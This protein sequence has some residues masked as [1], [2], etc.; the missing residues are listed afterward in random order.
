[1]A[2]TL[3]IKTIRTG[4]EP[5]ATALAE[6]E[7]G[8]KQVAAATTAAASGKLY[9]GEDV[10]GNAT[11]VA[12]AFGIGIKSG[13]GTTQTGVP[14]GGNLEIAAGS[15]ISTTGSVSGDVATVT[16]AATGGGGG[17]EDGDTIKFADGDASTPGLVLNSDAD[18]GFY[19]TGTVNELGFSA[20]GTGQVIFDDG[21]IKPVTDNDVDLGT[22]T[23]AFKN[24]YV[25]GNIFLTN[26]GELDIASGGDFTIDSSN[27]IKFDSSA[28]VWTYRDDATEIFR[29][30][31]SSSDVVMKNAV[32]AKDIIFTQYDDTETF[33]LTDD[34]KAKCDNLEVTGSQTLTSDKVVPNTAATQAITLDTAT[35]FHTI[36][37]D[38]TAVSGG[39]ATKTVTLT[40]PAWSEGLYLRI[41]CK[42]LGDVFSSSVASIVIKPASGEALNGLMYT[43]Q[44]HTTTANQEL[45]IRG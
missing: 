22:S 32:D 18:T 2:N 10:D 11:T 45:L 38:T 42:C 30:T 3:K 31:N 23:A 7:L 29:F 14:I 41:A 5:A 17:Y 8:V 6:A 16:I 13:A 36:I 9:Y 12:R 26:G 25:E 24:L 39:A 44:L 4:A 33:R 19:D 37:C 20:G 34:G 15:G 35:P 27:Q 40:L 28:G 43:Q 21:V 1:M